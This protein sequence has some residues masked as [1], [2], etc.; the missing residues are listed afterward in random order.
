[1]TMPA[2]N[3]TA[4]RR[5]LDPLRHALCRDRFPDARY[6]MEQRFVAANAV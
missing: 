3:N 1:M 4:V 2:S 5:Y 6:D